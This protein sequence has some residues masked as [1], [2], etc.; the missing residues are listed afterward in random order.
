MHLF[1]IKKILSSGDILNLH[2]QANIPEL[3]QYLQ[4][5]R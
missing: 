3:E 2:T 4:A 1:M 5:V